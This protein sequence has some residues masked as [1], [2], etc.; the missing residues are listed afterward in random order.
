MAGYHP[1]PTIIQKTFENT[2]QYAQ[3][4]CSTLL[5]GTFKPP[6]PALNAT[7]L[8][9]PVA[10]DITYADTTPAIKDGSTV[11]VIFVGVD[12]Q[13]TDVYSIKTDKQLVN[14]LED[15]IIAAWCSQQV[16]Q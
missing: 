8:N 13:V 9:E 10:C 6:N 15:N 12:T 14:T 3:I 16:N 5:K 4:P 2:I 1:P 7:R 11:A